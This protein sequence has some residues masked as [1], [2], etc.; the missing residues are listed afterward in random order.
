MEAISVK[1][2]SVEG[3]DTGSGYYAKGMCRNCYHKDHRKKRPELYQQHERTKRAKHGDKIRAYDRER[4]KTPE[5]KARVRDAYYA[6]IEDRHAY[7]KARYQ[8]PSRKQYMREIREKNRERVRETDRRRYERDK[9]KRLEL[10]MRRYA[11]KG[12]ATPKW[13]TKEHKN[14]LREIYKNRPEGHHVDHIV[15]IQGENVCGL[16]VP[17]NLQYLPAA[18]NIR[19]SNS[20]N[21]T[22]KKAA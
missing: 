18:E 16:H 20:F 4:G 19:K 21:P 9:P 2:C 1:V 11:N 15:P 12:L 10:V 6:N 13:L 14:Q 17:W 5:R 7:E 22:D 8:N 3:C